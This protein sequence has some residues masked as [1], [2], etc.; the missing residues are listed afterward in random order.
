MPALYVLR[1]ESDVSLTA[2]V[3]EKTH[4]SNVTSTFI[5]L[6]VIAGTIVL[7]LLLWVIRIQLRER[8]RE[9]ETLSQAQAA[10]YPLYNGSMTPP[11][12]VQTPSTPQTP[13]MPFRIPPDRPTEPRSTL[14]EMPAGWTLT[15]AAAP[16]AVRRKPIRSHARPPVVSSILSRSNSTAT[17]ASATTQISKFEIQTASRNLAFE[18]ALVPM[19]PSATQSTHRL[20][21][22]SD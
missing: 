10:H 1:S 18:A 20:H 17:N 15:V 19:P 13:A 4:G 14:P 12:M 3:P 11:F 9:R 8:R 6:V 22:E 5:V 7:A 2:P 16:S 21:R